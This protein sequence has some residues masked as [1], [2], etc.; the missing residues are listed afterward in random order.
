M[1][2]KPREA[3]LRLGISYPTLKKWI[4]SGKLH[5]VTT[6]GGHHRRP[7]AELD[8]FIPRSKVGSAALSIAVTTLLGLGFVLMGTLVI[9][10]YGWGLF[11]ALP[12]CLGMFSVLLY[13]Y[14]EPRE[15]IDCLAV[16][17]LPV[18]LVGAGV[19][20][21]GLVVLDAPP[22]QPIT[23]QMRNTANVAS[24][25]C[26]TLFLTPLNKPAKTAANA[27]GRPLSKTGAGINL[28]C[29]VV[30]TVMV[31]GAAVVVAV[32]LTVPGLTLQAVPA[33]APAQATV[34][35]PAKPLFPVV[36]ERL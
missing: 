6:P 16:A 31:T 25:A 23:T 2:L 12:F 9:G 26:R 33:G 27:N 4:Y 17:L 29:W 8:R 5:T 13:S 32:K 3:A 21:G 28:A 35:V 15:W 24:T 1:P 30:V 7:V 11:V 22:A 19:D 14:H 10:A 18:A 34:T 20:G 36:T